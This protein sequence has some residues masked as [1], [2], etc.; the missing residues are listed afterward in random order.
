MMISHKNL[1]K[2]IEKHIQ[3]VRYHLEKK[4][5]ENKIT[6]MKADH[7]YENNNIEMYEALSQKIDAQNKDILGRVR[8]LMVLRKMAVD[9]GTKGKMLTPLDQEL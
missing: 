7:A 6:R 1:M 3:D 2:A 4:Y 5:K 8:R 9:L